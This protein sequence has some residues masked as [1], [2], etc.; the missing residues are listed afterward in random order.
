MVGNF[1]S[2]LLLL[3]CICC[4]NLKKDQSLS[5][6]LIYENLPI[7]LDDL[8]YFNY[9]DN[10]LSVGIYEYV[11]ELKSDQKFI[12]ESFR[13]KYPSMNGR[14]LQSSLKLSGLPKKVNNYNVFLDTDNSFAFKSN[15]IKVSFVNIVVSED[16]RY[17]SI[18]VVKSLGSGSKFE[19]YYFKLM[20]EK[21][22]FDG[23]E[24]IALG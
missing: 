24:L 9:S 20:D 1:K 8:D 22:Y 2:I 7:L 5:K 19:I 14:I 3:F 15:I 11:G 4:Q 10:S 18:E 12:L 23:K 16:S 13:K 21:W 17:A 6:T